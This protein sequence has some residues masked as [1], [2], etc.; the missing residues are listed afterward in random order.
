MAGR[1]VSLVL[2][3]A[4]VIALACSSSSHTPTAPDLTV[5]RP[6]A[7]EIGGTHLWGIW[8]VALDPT[9]W[10][11]EIVPVRGVQFTCNVTQFL[12]PPIS[13][14]NLMGIDIDPLTDFITGHV[15]V[16]VIFT[17][18]FPGLDMYTGFDVRGVCIGNGTI[19]GIADSNI[20]YAG[21]EDLR[22]LNADGL[23]RWFNPSEFTKYGT[24]FGFTLGKMGAPNYDFNAT[25]NGYKYFCDGLESQDDVAQFFADPSCINPRGLFSAGNTLRRRY[26]L[27]FPTVGG[28]PQYRF[29]YAV[30]ASWDQP[31]GD[32]PYEIPDDFPLSA[33][34]QEA[35]CFSAADQSDMYYVDEDTSGGTLGLMVRVF[36]HQGAGT[37]SGV[38][39]EIGAI[40]IETPDGLITTGG[41]ATFE[42]AELSA[43]LYAE[44]DISATWLLSVEE[45]DPYGT[46]GY[47]VLVVVESKDPNSYDSGFPGFPFPE[48]ALASYLLTD[49][50]VTTD[51][52]P[53]VTAIDPDSGDIGKVLTAVEVT[54]N[55]FLD[56][57]Q[58]TLIKNDDPGVVIEATGEVASA[59][60]L[61]TCDLDLNAS[62]GAVVGVYDVRVTNPT[63]LYGE[64]PDGFEVTES[65]W[66]YW[67]EC[68]MYNS[69]HLGRNPS[70]TTADPLS[71]NQV[72]ATTA[73]GAYK[74]CTPVV[75]ENKIFFTSNTAFYAGTSTLVLGYNLTTGAQLWTAQ[76]DPSG[77]YQ[78]CQPG[79]AFY[80]A[81]DGTERLIV[82]GDKIYCFNAN[83]SGYNPTPLWTYDDT[84][85]SDQN[86]L[87]TQLTVYE[88]K[89]IAKG[90]LEAAMYILN[91]Q[92]GTL[93]HEVPI[94]AAFEAGVSAKDGKAYAVG[95]NW[96]THENY[97]DCVDIDSGTV[98]WSW[99]SGYTTI[100]VDHYNNPLI[101]N[102]RAYFASYAGEVYCVAVEDQ[103]AYSAGDLVW[104]Y[105]AT[106]ANPI[107]GGV[108]KLGDD[109]YFAC[110]FSGPVHCITDNGDYASLKWNSPMSGY[111][112]AMIVATV[113]PSYPNGIVI[114]PELN[115][116]VYFLDASNG[117][118]VRSIPTGE[119]QR[120]GAALAGD[121]L[122]VAGS[123]YVR[124]YQ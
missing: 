20:L 63:T 81:G 41:I 8:D 121:Y 55:Y 49:V 90:R 89:V 25:L 78:R 75:A 92:T 84:S 54:G 12:Q 42:G 38:A 57:A 33:N 9:T 52:A 74:Y 62:A 48:G 108:S 11:A 91:A 58:V 4:S 15:L 117:S 73:S 46:G 114:A 27:Q 85:P 96:G 13:P 100:T 68:I 2:A 69:S 66:P 53:I 50:S 23:T 93:I 76:I 86:W 120:G 5:E 94:M 34:C 39:D 16:D 19:Q 21:E 88:D 70:A 111:F 104:K 110:A 82:G 44:D 7:A 60:T 67:W 113:T 43:A 31:A 3:L 56:G 112:D 103:G 119:T 107:N 28:V 17:H 80:D 95:Y 115:G 98:D 123:S 24:I 101:D 29:Q 109:M 99:H 59:G 51:V 77:Y 116:T 10:T 87:G 106:P 26:D 71:L 124:A 22:V 72:Y 64:L 40:H 61:I 14:K 97:L 118:I 105:Q 47:P 32:Q 122:V 102:G 1:L 65:T 37:T 18:P 83:S 45:V 6:L 30:I 35:Y 79:F 36:D